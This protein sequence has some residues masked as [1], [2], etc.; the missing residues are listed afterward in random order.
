MI[1]N[2]H[3]AKA[4][5]SALLDQVEKGGEVTIARRGVPVARLVANAGPHPKRIG[6]LA[7][8]PYHFGEC[9]DDPELNETIARE[10]TSVSESK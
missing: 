6:G 1:V 3:E 4:K 2:I 5:L 9:F 8:R 10:F 7:G